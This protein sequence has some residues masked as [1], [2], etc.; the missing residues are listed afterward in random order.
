MA[1]PG[2]STPSRPGTPPAARSPRKKAAALPAKK[3][4]AKKAGASPAKATAIKAD[5]RP[6]A[7]PSMF[8]PK[9]RWADDT[10]IDDEGAKGRI[11]SAAVECVLRFGVDKTGMDDVAKAAN[12]TRQTVYKHFGSRNELIIA[13]FLRV[14]DT[15]L[16]RGLET[17]FDSPDSADALRD[18]IADAAAHVLDILRN[19]ETI[20]AILFGSRIA[21]EVLLSETANILVGVLQVSLTRSV[22][23]VVTGDLL[24][25]LRPTPFEE[26]S[27]WIIRMLYGFLAWPGDSLEAERALFRQY[28]S[29]IFLLDVV[30]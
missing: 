7:S 30:E 25:L 21:P 8:A 9:L 17:F 3:A 2:S 23:A 19:D 13:V 12:I 18:G 11:L 27:G 24:R 5:R 29:P 4:T 14:L 22:G 1:E 10:P 26:L 6:I 16:E 28:L 15:R 20:Q